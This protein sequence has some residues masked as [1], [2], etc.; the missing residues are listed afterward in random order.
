MVQDKSCRNEFYYNIQECARALLRA[1]NIS[2]YKYQMLSNIVKNTY[3]HPNNVIL[4]I[5][6]LHLQ[7][8]LDMLTK[9]NFADNMSCRKVENNI[10]SSQCAFS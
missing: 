1:N 8:F 2:K 9:S 3:H 6:K 7:G 4:M 5:R 10:H